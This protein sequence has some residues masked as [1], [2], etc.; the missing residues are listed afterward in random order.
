MSAYNGSG[1]FVVSGVGLP[2]VT[3]TTISSSVANQLNTDLATGL[4]TAICKDGQ[5]TPTANI[6]LG[7]F[8]L[9]G[10]GSPTASG[11]AQVFG[12]SFFNAAVADPTGTTSTA[13]IVMMGLGGTWALTPTITGRLRITVTGTANNTIATDGCVTQVRYGVG[14]APANAAAQTGTQAGRNTS[15]VSGVAS[16]LVPFTI[17]AQLSGLTINTAYWFDVGLAALTGG[18]ANLT[19]LSI[20]IVEY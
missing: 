17:I 12:A 3:A 14:A 11:D 1:T 7:G 6:P 18:V 13:S 9:T 2:Y 10:I 4:S 20:Q 15:A 19:Q 8:K 16:Q 5:T